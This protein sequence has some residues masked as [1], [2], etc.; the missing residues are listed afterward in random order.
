MIKGMRDTPQY[1]FEGTNT[2]YI[3][4]KFV[5]IIGQEFEFSFEIQGDEF[6]Y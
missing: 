2:N 1:N 5:M 3:I 6:K 4:V